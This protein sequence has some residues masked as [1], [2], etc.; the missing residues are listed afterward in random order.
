MKKVI[1]LLQ[2][3]AK[4]N[5]KTVNGATP[6]TV[7]IEQHNP[8]FVRMLAEFGYPMNEPFVWGETPLEMCM[9]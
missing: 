4:L 2:N 9:R 8:T 7:A 3:R 1:F 6:M 5:M